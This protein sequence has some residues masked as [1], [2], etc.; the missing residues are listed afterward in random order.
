[1]LDARFRLLESRFYVP[2]ASFCELNM[3]DMQSD[4]RIG[5]L[6]SQA[7]GLCHFLIH[8]D[9]GRYC[10]ALHRLSERRL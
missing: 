2:L 6:Y 5:M 9:S 8:A 7:A 1:M 4:P 10:D 3:T